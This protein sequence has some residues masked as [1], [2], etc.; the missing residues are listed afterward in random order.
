VADAVPFSI[1]IFLADGTPD[2]LRVVEKTNWTGVAYCFARTGFAAVRAG[3]DL[4]RPGVYVLTGPPE[5]EGYRQ[6]IYIGE[7]DDL[8]ARIRKH[9]IERE[10]WRQA[11]AFTSKDDDLNKAHVRYLEA[12]LLRLARAS[13]RA[14]LDNS[15]APQQP[16]LSAPERAYADAFL[17][18]MLLIY[19]I[20]GVEAFEAL[21]AQV[22]P[23]SPRLYL[24]G[25]S[26]SAEGR[27]TA[28]GLLVFA[29]ATARATV[30]PSLRD[31]RQRQRDRLIAEGVFEPHDDV[32]RLTRDYLFT[33]PSAA[34]TIL[35]GRS[36]NGRVLWKDDT[37]RT[38][39]EIQDA[40]LSDP[41]DLG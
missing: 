3:D 7:A 11:V 18:D 24:K 41:G 31:G 9:A 28:E 32:L 20:V 35:L 29:G 14:E 5:S 8:G 33:A 30:A 38:L 12:E 37:G 16:R 26:T 39:A 10:F 22:A 4:A 1:K 23:S 25:E 6:R 21:D 15:V 34:A 13:G 27:E 36:A 17:A 2:G 19:P 40:A